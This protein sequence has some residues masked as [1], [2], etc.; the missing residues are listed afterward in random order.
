MSKAQGRKRLNE[1][2][3]KI[4]AVYLAALEGK[5]GAV[6]TRQVTKLNSIAIEL[7]K[8]ADGLK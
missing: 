7:R 5:M 3:V 2:S 4:M 1:A 6:N 8:I